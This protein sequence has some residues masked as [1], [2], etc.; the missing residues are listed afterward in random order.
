MGILSKFFSKQEIEAIKELEL[1]FEST[2]KK[3]QSSFLAL[4][5]VSGKIKGLEIMSVFSEKFLED[6]K[7]AK[8][9]NAKLS[10]YFIRYQVLKLLPDEEEN[11]L[12]YIS[13][14]F[15]ERKNFVIFPV[16]GNESFII[17]GQTPHPEKILKDILR[18]RIVLYKLQ[19]ERTQE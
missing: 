3:S 5:G 11:P 19:M 10:E 17:T 8:R 6:H 14:N 16:E 9:Y 2:L 13:Y 12:K 15:G 4:V 1:Q 18:F 7:Q